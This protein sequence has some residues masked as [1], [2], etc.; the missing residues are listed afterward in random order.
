MI[1]SIIEIIR[2]LNGGT[3]IPFQKDE[4]TK[5]NLYSDN[6]ELYV[7]SSGAKNKFFYFAEFKMNGE[8]EDNLAQIE[9][10]LSDNQAFAVIGEPKPSDSYMILLKKNLIFS[11]KS[12]I[13]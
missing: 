12:N 8:N 2:T 13:V 11:I 4:I 7:D 6:V 10:E 9:S 3:V 5:M 1:N